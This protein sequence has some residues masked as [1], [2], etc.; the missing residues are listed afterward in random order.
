MKLSLLSAVFSQQKS[1]CL[2]LN[3]KHDFLIIVNRGKEKNEQGRQ[4]GLS[5]VITQWKRCI[6]RELAAQELMEK[7]PRCPCGILKVGIFH[8]HE[9]PDAQAI[10]GG[11]S[12]SA[13]NWV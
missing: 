8:M 10:R 1:N 9:A 12:N 2:I 4:P 11:W 3:E 13:Y 6:L 5:S 7:K